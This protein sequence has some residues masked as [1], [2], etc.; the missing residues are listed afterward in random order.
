MDTLVLF[1]G[2]VD[3]TVLLAQTLSEQR[4][5]MA[6]HVGYEHPAKLHEAHAVAAIRT[7]Y[8]RQGIGVAV[9]TMSVQISADQLYAGCG[10]AG[11]RVV[12]G[13]NACLLALATNFAASRGMSR[14]VFG[15]TAEDVA[16]YPDCRPDFVAAMSGLASA[17]GVTIEAPLIGLSRWQILQLGSALSAPIGQAWSCY[18]PDGGK[19]CGRCN[20]CTQ[21]G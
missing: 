3:S 6:L 2:G 5:G 17:W 11:A 7:E 12:P 8:A 19:Q 10:V 21:G 18:Q 4:L 1:S 16:G 13:R 9:H 14:V 20:S 15:A